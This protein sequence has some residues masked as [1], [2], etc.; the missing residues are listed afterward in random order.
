MLPNTSAR[1]NIE[2]G[3][4]RLLTVIKTYT[5]THDMNPGIETNADGGRRHDSCRDGDRQKVVKS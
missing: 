5:A 2:K 4:V 3:A 1:C